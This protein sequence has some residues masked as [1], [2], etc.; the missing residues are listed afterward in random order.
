[1]L[2]PLQ[3]GECSVVCWDWTDQSATAEAAGAQAGVQCAVGVMRRAEGPKKWQADWLAGRCL[4]AA[5]ICVQGVCRECR[6]YTK[7][8][9]SK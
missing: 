5:E 4:N 8:E 2:Q 7:E 3:K 9:N 6:A 1:M